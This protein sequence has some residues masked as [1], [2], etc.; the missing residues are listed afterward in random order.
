MCIKEMLGRIFPQREVPPA[1]KL[2]MSWGTDQAPPDPEHFL[3]NEDGRITYIS[4]NLIIIDDEI[5]FPKPDITRE[6]A[7]KMI[8]NRKP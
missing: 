8:K 4:D 6:V 2:A 3:V 5:V 1:E 7:R